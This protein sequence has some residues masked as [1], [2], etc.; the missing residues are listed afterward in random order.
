MDACQE[1]VAGW[2]KWRTAPSYRV[3]LCDYANAPTWCSPHL[4]PPILR[5]NNI[6]FLERNLPPLSFSLSLSR[7]SSKTK[8]PLDWIGSIRD[9]SNQW[10]KEAR[11]SVCVQIVTVRASPLSIIDNG[12]ERNFSQS[13][14]PSSPG[15]SWLRSSRYH[16][17]KFQKKKNSTPLHAFLLFLSFSLS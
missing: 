8:K 11:R 14:L 17:Q 9:R 6:S 10:D 12:E 13:A 2:K 15:F 1:R 3:P 16:L 7:S 4:R 5:D